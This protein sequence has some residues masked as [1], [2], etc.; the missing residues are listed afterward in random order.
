MRIPLLACLLS[1]LPAYA[2]PTPPV[3]IGAIYGFTGFANVWS[4]QA[5][6]GIEMARDEIN[7]SGGINGRPLEILFED[8]S[9]SAKGA[10]SAFNK[11]VRVDKVDAIVGD[12]ISFVTLPLVPLAQANKIV[13]IT[14]SIFDVDMPDNSDFFFTTCPE[15]S[16]IAPPVERFFSLN[17][18]V[19]RLAIICADNTWGRTYLDVWKSVANRRQIQ[20]VD[21]NCLDEYSSD[22]RAEVLRAKSKQ[23]DALIVAFNTDKA[24][25]GMK[26]LNFSPKLLMTSDIDEAVNRRGL[27]L[28]EARGVYFV[29]WLPT[30]EFTR[31]FE[32]RYREPPIMA[33]RNSYDAVRTIA[34]AFR[35]GETNLQSAIG[36]I[37]YFGGVGP[38]DFRTSRSGNKAA[39]SLMIVTERGIEPVP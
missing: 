27:P 34:E 38:I 24:L 36:K 14:P 15:K 31:N 28:Q 7:Q 6:R 1:V 23:P 21:E 26:E 11:L 22:M 18:E 39:A 5:R 2:E 32:R 29:D 33:P 17:P 3:K 10:V 16:S 25:Q 13:L 20:I 35:T 12:I 30:E 9:T 19:R 37:Y 8:S 4:A